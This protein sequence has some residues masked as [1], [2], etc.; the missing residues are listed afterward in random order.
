MKLNHKI[1]LAALTLASVA[2][3]ATTDAV[4]YTP[5]SEFTNGTWSLGWAFTVGSSN[6][7]VTALGT[8]SDPGNPIQESH[9][10]GI[11]TTGGTLL[12]MT[13]V[14]PS[15]Y[16]QDGYFA[17]EILGSPLAL[18]AGQTYVIAAETGSENYSYGGSLTNSADVSWDYDL[19]TYSS[20]L[21]MPTTSDGAGASY[22]GPNFQYY[23]TATTST[24]SPAAVIPFAV[25][26]VAAARRRR[27]G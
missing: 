17:D 12:A 1:A 21:V 24:P 4:T 16:V 25:G 6:I 15:L 27:N 5:G 23:T 8:F 3:H 18:S 10:V 20:S 22:F 11:F 13:T 7:D 14:N 9:D 2:A 26:L 19:Y